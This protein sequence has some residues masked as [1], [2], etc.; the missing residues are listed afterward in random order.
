[1]TGVNSHAR[2]EGI[3]GRS[4][5]RRQWL[6]AVPPATVAA[7]ATLALVGCA[8]PTA[9]RSSVTDEDMLDR[10]A[11]AAARD[12]ALARSAAAT[13]PDRAEELGIVAAQR[14]EHAAALRTEIAR[15]AGRSI[16]E[17]PASVDAEREAVLAELP[18]LMPGSPAGLDEVRAALAESVEATR[19]AAIRAIGHRSGL[20]ASVS[21]S[22]AAHLELLGGA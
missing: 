7:G 5:T 22:C 13:S 3:P 4:M 12:A 10:H 8:A 11:G 14:V 20:L 17:P 16:T 9:P 1:M 15:A 18:A 6:A 2:P 19:R 21:A